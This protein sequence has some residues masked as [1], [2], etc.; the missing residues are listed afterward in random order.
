TLEACCEGGAEALEC[1]RQA[2]AAGRPI[3]LVFLDVQMPEVD[4]LAVASQLAGSDQP[5]VPAVAFVTAVDEFAVRAFEGPAID[6]LLKPFSDERFQAALDRAVRHVTAGQA[7]TLVSR[8]QAL[9]G[10]LTPAGSASDPPSAAPRPKRPLDRI[11]VRGAHRVRL[12]PV[13]QI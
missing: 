11:V 10:N 4:G 13:D 7:H 6:Y 8:M 2:A 9:L 5:S 3:D 1:V 12:L